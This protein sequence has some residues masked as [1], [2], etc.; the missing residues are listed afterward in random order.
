MRKTRQLL[1]ALAL[2]SV[3]ATTGVASAAQNVQVTQVKV[4][5]RGCMPARAKVGV[6]DRIFMR[7]AAR[8]AVGH[9]QLLQLAIDRST[10]PNVQNLA[11]SSRDQVILA[12]TQLRKIADQN[13]VIL[14]VTPSRADQ[15]RYQRLSKL[16][17]SEFNK[18]ILTDL[19]QSHARTM[20]FFKAESKFGANPELRQFAQ[21]G[22]SAM[23]RNQQQVCSLLGSKKTVA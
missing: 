5:E 11:R 18:A 14:P 10:D 21:N 16:S 1:S 19:S 15:A 12:N 3:L 7:R 9:I 17:G 23:M 20:A 13:K 4:S 6:C 8:A 2:G 22:V